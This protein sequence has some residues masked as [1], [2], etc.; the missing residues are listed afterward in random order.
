MDE[1]QRFVWNKV[2]TGEF[3]VGVQQNL[4]IRAQAESS[5]LSQ[6][7]LAHRLMGDWQPT[8]EFCARLLAPQTSQAELSR[9]DP[10]FLAYTLEGGA[11]SLGDVSDWQAE[12]KWDGI[13]AQ[14]IR[15]QGRTWLCPAART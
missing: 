9:P 8:P 2:I 10:F 7:A 13:R 15:R 12:W 3:R 6:A 4:V 14:L 5:G 11:H 1:G